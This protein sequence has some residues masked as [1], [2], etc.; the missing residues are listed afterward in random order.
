[1]RQGLG[2]D[3]LE[4]WRRHIGRRETRRQT[5]DSESLRRYAAAVGSP[6]DIAR[7]P[8]PLAHWAYFLDTVATEGLGPDGHPKRGGLI[9]PITLP[10]RQFAA[11]EIRCRHPLVLEAPAELTLTIADIRHRRGR[12]GDLVFVELDRRLAQ[13]GDEILAE[14]QTI[15]YRDAGDRVAPV[16]PVAPA[17]DGEAWI[18]GPVDLFRFSAATFNAHRIHYDLPYAREAEG[19]PGLVVHGPLVAARLFA[20]ARAQ[21]A[22]AV[23]G[24]AFRITA[25]LFAGQP[26]RFARGAEAGAWQAIRCD[27]AVAMTAR[28]D[29]AGGDLGSEPRN[30]PKRG[31]S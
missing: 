13:D 28:L 14:R 12:A 21:A 17:P 7:A 3:D 5:L 23:V 26:I 27:G 11:A 15:V 2:A 25:P 19:Y 6:L 31:A 29:E 8:P 20:H 9:P 22:G 1:M 18:P 30:P 16:T 10:R 24:F 4:G